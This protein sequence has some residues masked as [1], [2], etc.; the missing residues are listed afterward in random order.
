MNQALLG[1]WLW[2]ISEDQHGL[3]NQIIAAK[4]EVSRNGWDIK[5]PDYNTWNLEGSAI[6]ERSLHE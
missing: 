3:R 2:R 1:K 6:T 5:D 4:Y